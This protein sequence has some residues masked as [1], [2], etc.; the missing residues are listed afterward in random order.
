[1]FLPL[2]QHFLRVLTRSTDKDIKEG[3]AALH[4]LNRNFLDSMDMRARIVLQR[5]LEEG[6]GDPIPSL[7][8]MLRDEDTKIC[9]PA[10]QLLGDLGTSV[11]DPVV[12]REI[13]QALVDAL[14]AVPILVELSP[15][16]ITDA[17]GPMK[18]NS[19]EALGKM[20]DPGAVVE[21]TEALR[22]PHPGVRRAAAW[23]LG[24]INSPD[25]VP[26]LEEALS[27]DNHDARGS[28]IAALERIGTPEALDAL[29]AWRNRQKS[30]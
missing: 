5:A 17:L 25:A 23:A 6:N 27:D 29:A 8:R 14:H 28:A 22:N 16:F 1:M 3:I 24:C 30:E 26:G 19:A 11:E 12:R 4:K 21:L 7:L 15:V 20:R 2:F 9:A 10:A 18:I 13:L